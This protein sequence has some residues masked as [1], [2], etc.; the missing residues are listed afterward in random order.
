[1]FRQETETG[2]SVKAKSQQT[3]SKLNR[4]VLYP[5]PNKVAVAPKPNQLL[6]NVQRVFIK[7][8]SLY[9]GHV[10]ARLSMKKTLCRQDADRTT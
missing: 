3:N 6:H 2:A 9:C 10:L 7:G 1:M 8:P 4:Q 5:K